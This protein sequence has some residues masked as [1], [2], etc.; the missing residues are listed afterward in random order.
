[1]EMSDVHGWIRR[2]VFRS[3]KLTLHAAQSFGV[4]ASGRESADSRFADM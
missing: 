3:S 1:M 4:V 2:D